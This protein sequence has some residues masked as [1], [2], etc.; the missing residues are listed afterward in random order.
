MIGVTCLAIGLSLSAVA[1]FRSIKRGEGIH[2][3][4]MAVVGIATNTVA[5]LFIIARMVFASVYA[6]G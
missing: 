4:V 3:A 2:V 5:F 1:L 6:A